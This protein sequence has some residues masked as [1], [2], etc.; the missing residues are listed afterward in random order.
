MRD[1]FLNGLNVFLSAVALLTAGSLAHRALERLIPDAEPESRRLLSWLVAAVAIAM[2]TLGLGIAG[3]VYSGV[4][5]TL[6]MGILAAGAAP[7]IRD[8]RRWVGASTSWLRAGSL[9]EK[10]LVAAIVLRAAL[11]LLGGTLQMPYG[12]SES[13]ALHYH[14]VL[15]RMYLAQ[16]SMANL[17]WSIPDKYPLFFHMI[18]LAGFAVTGPLFVKT[19]VFLAHVGSL[20]LLY[21]IAFRYAERPWPLWAVAVF[22]GVPAIVIQAG[23]A[24]IDTLTLF[25]LLLSLEGFLR[26]QRGGGLT[27][28]AASALSAGVVGASRAFTIAY[29]ILLAGIFFLARWRE[30]ANPSS[31]LREAVLFLSAVF[32]LYVP[33]AVRAWI[34]TGN[35]VFP[36]GYRW[37][38][39]AGLE[40]GR[41]A[42]LESVAS[43]YGVGKGLVAAL[44]LPWNL[45]FHFQPFDYPVGPV[46]LAFLPLLMF[47]CPWK[48]VALPAS[49]AAMFGLLW[50]AGS[51][52]TRYLYFPLAVSFILFAATMDAASRQVRAVRVVIGALLAVSVGVSFVQARGQYKA[53]LTRLFSGESNASYLGRYVRHAE[54]L[55]MVR[56]YTP[57]TARILLL[58][59]Y[60]E[61]LFYFPRAF[62]QG[63]AG[64]LTTTWW[65]ARQ[66]SRAS[67]SAKLIGG[68]I[69]HLCADKSTPGLDL[70]LA[71]GHWTLITEDKNYALY[72]LEP[73]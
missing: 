34:K 45:T 42:G 53:G 8:L 64:V 43:S 67:F 7:F 59:G 29:A 26:Y 55:A 31:V 36:L 58:D 16:H 4:F 17:E 61:Y 2:G 21:R 70:Y 9:V 72:R 63:G 52:Q 46:F 49:I 41:V 19:F 14:L 40:A 28:L 44:M 48:K 38:G 1:S 51:Q 32:A 22:G 11:I 27:A 15:P 12:G 33:W 37:F 57:E 62:V 30:G 69:T 10:G 71:A 13:D 23:T 50:F 54:S 3:G 66:Q 47:F 73:R 25:F 56:T 39:G 20:I 68:G 65:D 18:F 5:L 35:P 24:M 60:P 6:W